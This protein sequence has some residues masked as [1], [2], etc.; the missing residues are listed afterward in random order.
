MSSTS[1]VGELRKVHER[2]IEL[3]RLNGELACKECRRCGPLSIPT[4]LTILN[5]TFRTKSGCDKKVG[6]FEL[7]H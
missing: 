7:R 4:S 3:K 2:E 5:C 6:G 1:V